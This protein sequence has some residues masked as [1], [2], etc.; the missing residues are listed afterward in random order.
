MIY[1]VSTKMYRHS[2]ISY[3]HPNSKYSLK[4]NKIPSLP[5]S[6]FSI[7]SPDPAYTPP[8][9]HDVCQIN[10]SMGIT[11]RLKERTHHDKSISNSI[12]EMFNSFFLKS[13]GHTMKLLNH[14]TRLAASTEMEVLGVRWMWL[15]TYLMRSVTAPATTGEATLVPDSER[16]PPLQQDGVDRNLTKQPSNLGPFHWVLSAQLCSSVM[17]PL[18]G[19]LQSVR[20]SQ[21]L[22]TSV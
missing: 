11:E 8:L 7:H 13:H 1:H 14:Q 6:I 20:N 19:I 21:H 12:S 16:H 5:S 22:L 3:L 2:D 10:C 4:L 9:H 15:C 18:K 17:L